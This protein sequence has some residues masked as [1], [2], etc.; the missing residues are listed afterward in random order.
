MILAYTIC[1]LIVFITNVIPAFMPSTWI[2][3]S[4]FYIRF[5]LNIWILSVLSAIFSGLGRYLL[6]LFSSKLSSRFL[7]TKAM[8]NV[9]YLGEILKRHPK[10]TFAL[11]FIWAVAPL[12][13]NPFFIALGLSKVN[14]KVA[15]FPFI[16]GR[17]LTY[18]FFAF[19]SKIIYVSLKESF[20]ESFTN[21]IN[22]LIAV[23]GLILILLYVMI[24]WQYLAVKRKLKLII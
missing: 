7:N 22:L 1:L 5:G 15:V 18:L 2:V 6:A 14:I 4:Y 16:I 20:T 13:S 10:W 17:F 21:P 24:D 12:P 23:S 8:Q 9:K 19:Y 3:V 11:S